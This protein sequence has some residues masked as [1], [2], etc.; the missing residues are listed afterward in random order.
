M[1]NLCIFPARAL[2]DET[3]TDA[4]LRVLAAI[5]V[6]TDRNGD[7]RL[8]VRTILKRAKVARSTFFASI[9]RLEAAGLIA[10]VSGRMKGQ[11]SSYTVILDARVRVSSQPDSQVSSQPD[12]GVQPGMDTPT[13]NAPINDS[14][15]SAPRFVVE[16]YLPD[17]LELLRR[18]EKTGGLTAS[19]F[20]ECNAQLD[21][22][23]GK[24]ATALQISEAIRHFAG[25]GAEP[26]L[27]LFTGYLRST[28]A[29][30]RK[31]EP[32]PPKRRKEPYRAPTEPEPLGRAL[33]DTNWRE[34]F[35][36]GMES[37]PTPQEGT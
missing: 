3:I 6:H 37:S 12:S 11:S 9:K 31:N 20:G 15:S 27:R 23:H 4:D 8:F 5:G 13:I 33:A 28:I 7:C 26:N 25:N 24:A 35:K 18:V 19:W 32:E 29:G 34:L 21:G 14:S 10:R 22:M 36:Q 1:P 2:E 16:G 30:P 17:W